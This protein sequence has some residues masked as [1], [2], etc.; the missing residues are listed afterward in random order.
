MK[1][2]EYDERNQKQ[3]CFSFKI[4]ELLLGASERWFEEN[5]RDSGTSRRT[6]QGTFE[7][8]HRIDAEEQSCKRK[9]QASCQ[10]S[11]GS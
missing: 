10:R 7:E 4:T 1:A 9:T 8:E 2:I 11:A 5:I 3:Q 6:S